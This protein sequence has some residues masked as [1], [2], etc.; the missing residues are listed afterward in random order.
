MT[1]AQQ[2]TAEGGMDYARDLLARVMG[3]AKARDLLNRTSAV[4]GKGALFDFLR[5]TEPAQ[6]V[7]SLESEHPQTIALVL[8]HLPPEFSGRVL[9]GFDYELQAEV[10]SRIALMGK[11][12]PEVTKDVEM[13]LRRK[14]AAYATEGYRTAGGVEYLVGVLNSVD[15]RT[16]RGILESIEHNDPDLAAEIRRRMFVFEDLSALDDRAMQR[17]LRDVTDKDLGLA[18]RAASEDVKNKV[19]KNK[20]PRAAEMLKGDMAAMG[21][22]RLRNIEEAQQKI[23]NVIRTLQ[24][25]EEIV[26]SRSSEDVFV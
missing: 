12:A 9:A 6:L 3:T 26:I 23:L 15:T 21:P 13:I 19:F 18:L 17:I 11:T 1:L 5:H 25:S 22:V 24:E 10:A 4:D 20:S 7:S 2:Y 8:S 16:E 14:L